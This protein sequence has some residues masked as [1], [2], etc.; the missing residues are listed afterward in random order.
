MVYE[1]VMEFKRKHRG[2]I[3]WRIMSH[4]K[5]IEKHLNPGEEVLLAF[6]GQSNES[7][8][9]IFDTSVLV[10]TNKRI[11]VG[12]KRLLFGYFLK[13]ITPDLFNDLSVY[14]GI[15]WGRVTIDTVKEIIH[16]TNLSKDGL[17]EIETSITEYMMREKRKYRPREVGTRV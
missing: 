14:S 8:A 7:F 15:I 6:A 9:D 11:L 3:A 5:V 4:C 1:K 10:L 17:D 16:F 2:G 12:Q 13:A